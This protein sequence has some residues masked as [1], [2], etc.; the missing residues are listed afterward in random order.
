MDE[1]GQLE[2]DIWIHKIS[3]VALKGYSDYVGFLYRRRMVHVRSQGAST[4]VLLKRGWYIPNHGLTF[5]E[6]IFVIF[7]PRYI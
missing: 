6:S 2:G 7:C 5:F 4:G 1:A 3:S